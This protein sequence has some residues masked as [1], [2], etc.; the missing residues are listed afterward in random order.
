MKS[1]NDPIREGADDAMLDELLAE[2]RWPV[3]DDQAESRLRMRWS[4]ARRSERSAYRPL[5]AAAAAVVLI[6]CGIWFV[7][8]Q[9]A[10][11]QPKIAVGPPVVP[12]SK[13]IP[14]PLPIAKK[15]DRPPLVRPLGPAERLVLIA[16]KQLAKQ[17]PA[18]PIL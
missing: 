5:L 17:K 10:E 12:Q 11:T 15:A 16:D 13:S 9:H 3:V 14:S 18:T 7:V 8:H 1:E 4:M 6:A 2:A